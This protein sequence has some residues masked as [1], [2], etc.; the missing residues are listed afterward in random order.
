MQ[1]KLWYQSKT[2]WFN[3][4]SAVAAILVMLAGTPELADYALW[5]LVGS[6]AINIIIRF[7]FTETRI[8]MK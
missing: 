6:N 7:M 4:L 8:K 1:E 2:F 5:F 3:L